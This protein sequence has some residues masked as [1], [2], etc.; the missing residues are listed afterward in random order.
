[1]ELQREL[2]DEYVQFI[3]KAS[4]RFEW[5]IFLQ[6]HQW[7]VLSRRWLRYICALGKDIF[8]I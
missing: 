3:T 2:H 1:M 6:S 7:S 5:A 4:P 8:G